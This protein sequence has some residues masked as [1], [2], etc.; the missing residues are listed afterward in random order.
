V[1]EKH[2]VVDHSLLRRYSWPVRE[3]GMIVEMRPRRKDNTDCRKAIVQAC[4]LAA[5]IFVT[6]NLNMIYLP[7]AARYGS[8]TRLKA[9]EVHSNSE[10]NNSIETAVRFV[11]FVGLEGVG[12]HFWKNAMDTSPLSQR[13]EELQIVPFKVVQ[14]SLYST[15]LQS[16]RNG[17][18]STNECINDMK[19]KNK[20]GQLPLDMVQA[21]KNLANALKKL[22]DV[23]QFPPEASTNASRATVENPVYIPL[24]IYKSRQMMSYPNFL[25][26]NRIYQYP[27]IDLLSKTCKMANVTCDLVYLYRNP[28]SVVLSTTK[29]RDFNDNIASAIQLYTVMLSILHYQLETNP[30][31]V[32]GCWDY[33]SV[34]PTDE[35]DIMQIRQHESVRDILGWKHNISS[36]TESLS[37]IY[38]AK[39]PMNETEKE[40]IVPLQHQPLM[41]SLIEIHD[42]VVDLCG[43]LYDKKKNED[44]LGR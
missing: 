29:N 18:F 2:G 35:D 37:S 30:H 31:A 22:S 33:D 6:V 21:K 36:Y 11:F 12:H 7:E 41:D 16:C 9:A 38:S 44:S 3:L 15:H 27:Q 26:T 1:L 24:N 28:Y 42:H 43:Q 5:V 8:S 32:A 19:S 23:A 4:V 39:K 17:I 20:T 25:G 14:A 34:L 10:I 13:L 40:A